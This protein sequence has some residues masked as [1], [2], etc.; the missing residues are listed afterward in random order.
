MKGF[1]HEEMSGRLFDNAVEA[2]IESQSAGS[3][4]LESMREDRPRD[5]AIVKAMVSL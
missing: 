1:S 5:F 2:A 4:W 3:R